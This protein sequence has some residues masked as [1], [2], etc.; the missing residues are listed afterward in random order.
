MQKFDQIH[1]KHLTAPRERELELLD[2]RYKTL[3]PIAKT[4]TGINAKKTS[5]KI[6]KG[7]KKEKETFRAKLV[8][9]V[10]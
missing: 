6:E 9:I 4:H 5:N 2:A 1:A 10:M 7:V 8:N 3:S